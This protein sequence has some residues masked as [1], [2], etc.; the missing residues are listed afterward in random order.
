MKRFEDNFAMNRLVSYA[1]NSLTTEEDLAKIDAFFKDKQTEKYKLS[2]A[3]TRDSIMASTA[4]LQRDLKDVESW[5]K[6]N[7]FM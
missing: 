1:F 2:L 4:W 7:Q 3:Q 5:L 6:E